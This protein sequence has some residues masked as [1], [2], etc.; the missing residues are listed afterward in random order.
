MVDDRIYLITLSEDDKSKNVGRFYTLR[1][2]D[3]GDIVKV[4][5]T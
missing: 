1:R 5:E 2:I 3:I 4:V